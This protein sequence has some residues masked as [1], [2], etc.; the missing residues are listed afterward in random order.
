M[1]PRTMSRAGLVGFLLIFAIVAYV[2][3][4]SF[5]VDTHTCEVCMEYEGESQCR[6]VSA[7]TIEL[8]R[9]GAIQN[10]CAYISGGVTGSIG[11]GRGTPL[12]EKCQ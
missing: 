8:A 4:G 9:Q 1:V 11:C 3:A 6:T 10:A 5:S 12:S 7:A 2:I